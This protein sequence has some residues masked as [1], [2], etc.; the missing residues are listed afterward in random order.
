MTST[1][2]HDPSDAR[3]SFIR[4]V[5]LAACE[6]A[7]SGAPF[8]ADDIFRKVPETPP[9]VDRRVVGPA[10]NGL[11]AESLIEPVALHRLEVGRCHGRPQSVWKAKDPDGCGRWI[12]QNQPRPE[13]PPT[14]VQLTLF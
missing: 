4:S 9:G 1:P 7:R 11:R 10:L 3:L 2:A 6:L 14:K 8:D 5:Q 13:D 12:A